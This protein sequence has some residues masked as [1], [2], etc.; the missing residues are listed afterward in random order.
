MG[1]RA[2]GSFSLSG[3]YKRRRE[4]NKKAAQTIYDGMWVH[5][6][7]EREREMFPGQRGDVLQCKPLNYQLVG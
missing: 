4:G 1:E 3:E 6:V 2:S 7:G 5:L